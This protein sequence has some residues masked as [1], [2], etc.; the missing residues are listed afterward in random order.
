[1]IEIPAI[2]IAGQAG[3]LFG[4][5]MIGWSSRESLRQR[6]R[7]VSPDVMTLAFGLAIMLVWAGA[8][9][10]FFSQFHEPVLPYA[11]KILFGVIE[12]A[13]LVLFLSRKPAPEKI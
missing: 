8:V 12:L 10:A 7:K 2:L 1:V 3:L 4:R 5:A 9:E 13:A 6:L 11:L